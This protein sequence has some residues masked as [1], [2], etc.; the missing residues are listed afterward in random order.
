MA[1]LAVMGW[2]STR[3]GCKA[4]ST[5]G[6][7]CSVPSVWVCSSALGTWSLSVC[8]LEVRSNIHMEKI[9]SFESFFIS[10]NS[11]EQSGA[12]LVN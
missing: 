8:P 4:Q 3:V 9:C 1:P 7:H 10:C 12:G 2:I 11:T 6:W 5:V